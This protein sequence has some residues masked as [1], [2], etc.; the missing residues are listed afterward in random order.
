M[1]VRYF[2]ET[3]TF[4]L[5]TKQTTYQMKMDQYGYLLHL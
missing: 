5:E 2:E 1:A 4:I 3:K